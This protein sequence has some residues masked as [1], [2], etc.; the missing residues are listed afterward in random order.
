M[1]MTAMVLIASGL[2]GR[3]RRKGTRRVRMTKT[4]AAWVASDSTAIALGHER[5]GAVGVADEG[6]AHSALVIERQR[7][8]E[9]MP[10]A[11]RTAVAAAALRPGNYRYVRAGRPDLWPC[12]QGSALSSW[13]SLWL[14]PAPLSVIT[15]IARSAAGLAPV[16]CPGASPR[17]CR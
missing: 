5:L 6:R 13:A 2:L 8:P 14:P 11:S 15:T 3:L 17:T 1:T 9:L 16:G 12:G 10:S 7:G 4:T